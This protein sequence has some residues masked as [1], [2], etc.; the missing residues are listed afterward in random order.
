MAT[1]IPVFEEV[2]TGTVTLTT[3][4]WIDLGTIPTGKQHWF[5]YATYIAETKGFTFELRTN[6]ATKSAP[7]VADTTLHD[8]GAANQ[9]SVDRDFYQYGNIL[10]SSVIST[11]VEKSWLRIRS[12]TAAS[13]DASYIIYLTTY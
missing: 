2:K 11:G 4:L 6:K 5:G 9:D 12:G 7:T 8:F 1:I 3:E 13:G 10:S